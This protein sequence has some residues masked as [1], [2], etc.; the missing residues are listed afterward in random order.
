MLFFENKQKKLIEGV[1]AEGKIESL[2]C[3]IQF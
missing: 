2:G 1:Q 3:V